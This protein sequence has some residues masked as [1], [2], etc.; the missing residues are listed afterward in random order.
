MC[1]SRSMIARR[2]RQWR[3]MLTCVKITE[4]SMSENEF[5]RTSCDNT[6]CRTAEPEIT[7]PGETTELIAMPVRP[8]SPNKNFAGGYCVGRVRI[9][10]SLSYRLKIGEIEAMSRFAS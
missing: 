3:P 10:Q 7:H 8:I 9:G 4:E 1:T 6:L 5:T 2:I